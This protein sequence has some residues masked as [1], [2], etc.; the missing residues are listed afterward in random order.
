MYHHRMGETYGNIWLLYN[1]V[2][3]F[4]ALHSLPDSVIECVGSSTAQIYLS[5]YSTPQPDLPTLITTCPQRILLKVVY[6]Y[7]TCDLSISII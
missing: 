5:Y 6:L 1:L 3:G 4:I 7:I 2:E